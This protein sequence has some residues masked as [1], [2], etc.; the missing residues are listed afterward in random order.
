MNDRYYP[1]G[2]CLDDSSTVQPLKSACFRMSISITIMRSVTSDP[3]VCRMCR[4]QFN[5]WIMEHS[6]FETTVARLDSN[7]IDGDDNDTRFSVH[8]R[9]HIIR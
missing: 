9:M 5:K 8:V 4:L 2:I 3:K 1:Y 6:G 7:L